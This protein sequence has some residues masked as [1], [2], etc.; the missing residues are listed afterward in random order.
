MK[1]MI[2]SLKDKVIFA[3][4]MLLASPAFAKSSDTTFNE[5]F[6]WIKTVLEGSGGTVLA[7]LALVVGAAS[8]IVGA[9][10]TM[11]GFAVVFVATLAGPTVIE[12]AYSAVF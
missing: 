12:A 5:M 8:A 3:F 4:F 1:K 10:K 9:Y 6:T 11:I 2:S 7:I